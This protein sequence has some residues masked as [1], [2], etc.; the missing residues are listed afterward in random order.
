VELCMYCPTPSG[1]FYRVMDPVED[2]IE[3]QGEMQ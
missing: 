1:K 2:Q 3:E